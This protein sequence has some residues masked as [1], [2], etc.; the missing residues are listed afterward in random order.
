MAIVTLT[1]DFGLSDPYVAEMKGAILAECPSAVLV[2]VT[3]AILSG[4]IREAAWIA[5]NLGNS[6]SPGTTHIVIVDP[7]VGSARRAL[8]VQIENQVF[9]AP[10]NGVLSP[11]I[12][13]SQGAEVCELSEVSRAIETR[14]RRRE[15]TTFEGRDRFAP[16][17]GCLAAGLPFRE[18]GAL[19]HDP[20]S[21][22]PFRPARQERG[23]KTEVVRVDRFGNLVTC[24]R[25]RFLRDA[26]GESWREVRVRAGPRE[27]IG[28][29]R[30]YADVPTKELVLTIGSSESLEV[31]Q[32]EG[33]AADFLG[34][35]RGDVVT[36]LPPR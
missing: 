3:H 6:F 15:T 20:V 32:N 21:I 34:I 10:D 27:V 2:D 23:W 28:V 33:H 14:V 25:V 29:R 8:A 26:F 13:E 16:V 12:Q 36:I 24:A 19:V 17:A 1:T 22:E 7:G 31:S 5:C 4:D 35:D 11:L 18:L 30:S 9:L